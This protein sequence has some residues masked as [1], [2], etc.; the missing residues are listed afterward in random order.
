MHALGAPRGPIRGR[1]VKPRGGTQRVIRVIVTKRGAVM[2]RGRMG[3]ST[4]KVTVTTRVRRGAATK[5]GTDT[6]R[7]TRRGTVVTT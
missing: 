5:I 7:E 6:M 2:K 4:R 1:R 3:D